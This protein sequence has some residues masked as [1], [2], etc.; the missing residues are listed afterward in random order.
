MKG[1]KG[2]KHG[3]RWWFLSAMKSVGASG[4]IW[5]ILFSLFCYL[6]SDILRHKLCTKKPVKFSCS[7]FCPD[8]IQNLTEVYTVP[9]LS[10]KLQYSRKMV[11]SRSG[12]QTFK[13][14]WPGQVTK[15]LRLWSAPEADTKQKCHE[16]LIVSFAEISGSLA[17]GTA[18]LNPK[19]GM[20]IVLPC[21]ASQRRSCGIAQD[22]FPSSPV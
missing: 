22:N 13:V 1:S 8:L 19:E 6:G 5:V 11:R 2:A 14:P 4:L 15:A 7:D 9:I 10:R 3:Q 21:W 18:I 12:Q 16:H 20:L 17:S